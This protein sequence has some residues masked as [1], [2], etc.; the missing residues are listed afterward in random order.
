M[1][2]KLTILGRRLAASAAT[3]LAASAATVL[4]ASAAAVLV[5]S[6]AFA[7]PPAAA[8]AA[9][10]IAA[11]VERF[12]A[13]YLPWEPGTRVTAKA[14][15]K[16]DVR[17]FHAWMIERK[18]KYDKLDA[19]E[20]MLVSADEKWIFT[21]NVIKN[22]R[23]QNATAVIRTDADVSG[24][25]S[26]FSKMFG[27][28][29]RA[30]LEAPA[31][32]AGLN[33]VRVEVDTGY[34]SQPLHYYVEPDGSVFFMGTLWKL[35]EPV[36]D[37]RRAIINLTTSPSYGADNP[38]ITVVE[39]ADMECPFCKRRGQQMDKLMDKYSAKLGI[40]RYYKFFPLWSTHHWST[41]AA[42]AAV[43]LQKFSS[44]LVFRFKQICYD[45]QDT[46]TLDRLDQ[47]V[48]DFVDSAGIPR[49]DFLACYLQ[50]ASFAAIRR[51]MNEGG[52]LGVNSTP[53][54]YVNGVEIYW[55]PDDVMED[56]LKSGAATKKR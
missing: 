29:A 9:R 14:D 46:L 54:Y 24:I 35:A 30:F 3:V 32:K 38:K 16:N 48:F 11:E 4:A 17:G 44:D 5:A 56:F 45:N 6:S 2:R 43:C 50:D 40:R 19:K 13:E 39:Y 55:L 33:G 15:P 26:Y 31:D 18:G 28:N 47:Q 12:A 22:S 42:S 27:S 34:F 21:G 25:G 41:K 7:A 1:N 52:Y 36:A 10:G 37:Q 49:K 8:P 53:T 51:D 23:P 20:N